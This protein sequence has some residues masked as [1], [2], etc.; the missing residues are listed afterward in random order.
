MYGKQRP[1]LASEPVPLTGPEITRGPVSPSRAHTEGRS[2]GG[3]GQHQPKSRDPGPAR[4]RKGNRQC[5]QQHADSQ[6]HPMVCH[7]GLGSLPG[8]GACCGSTVQAL[9][10][11]LLA[12]LL[13]SSTSLCEDPSSVTALCAPSP[14][15]AFPD[16]FS[17]HPGSLPSCPYSQGRS[18]L[19]AILVTP[20][21]QGLGNRTGSI[22]SPPHPHT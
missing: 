9:T 18:R 11:S 13:G 15:E 21:K 17:R 3:Q 12:C 7:S 10:S 16:C 8:G 5:P 20:H 22:P 2:C 19:R 6:P 14:Q 1:S 4:R